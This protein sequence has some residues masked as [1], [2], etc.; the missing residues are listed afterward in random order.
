MA[1]KVK[2]GSAVDNGVSDSELAGMPNIKLRLDVR[3]TLDGNL[4]VADHPDVDIIIMPKEK[5][6]LSLAKELDSSAVYGAANRLFDYLQGRGVVEPSS[7]QGGNIYA[8]IQ[9]TIPDAEDL[10]TIKIALINV[11]KWLDLEEPSMS[12]IDSYEKGIENHYTRP[13]RIYS[14]ELGEVPAAAEKGSIKPS[15][16]RGPYGLSM[17]NYYG[18]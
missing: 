13:S 18:Y 7:I 8:S 14:T 17:Y 11:A 1:L 2:I 16:T 15:L 3:K 10:P 4:I 5:K 9:G 12:R 6:V